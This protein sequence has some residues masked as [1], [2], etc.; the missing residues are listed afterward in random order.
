MFSAFCGNMAT[1]ISQERAA[2]RICSV[3]AVVYVALVRAL[4]L[5]DSTEKEMLHRPVR[6]RNSPEVANEII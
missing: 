3:N 2:A 1:T 4:R 5:F 6:R